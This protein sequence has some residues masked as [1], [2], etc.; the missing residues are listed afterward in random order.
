[1][2]DS[3]KIRKYHNVE[4]MKIVGYQTT[5]FQRLTWV[6]MMNEALVGK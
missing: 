3:P 1:M 5:R 2:N 6:L 4:Q